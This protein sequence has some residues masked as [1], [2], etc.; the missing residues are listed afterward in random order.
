MCKIKK[1]LKN[2]RERFTLQI[3]IERVISKQ[4]S[5][6]LFNTTTCDDDDDDDDEHNVQHM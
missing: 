4:L 2:E 5:T 6:G 1:V 3:K